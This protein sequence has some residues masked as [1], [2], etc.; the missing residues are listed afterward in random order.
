MHALTPQE[1]AGM[2]GTNDA[3]LQDECRLLIRST[4][5]NGYGEERESFVSGPLLPCVFGQGKSVEI[6][7]GDQTIRTDAQIGLSIDIAGVILPYDRILLTKRF[8]VAL[9]TPLEFQIVGEAARGASRIR[10]DLT[11]VVL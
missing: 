6:R 11:R 10:L 5:Q 2:Q 9:A 1:L 8:D 4:T 3:A 7:V